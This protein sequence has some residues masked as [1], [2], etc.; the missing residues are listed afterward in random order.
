MQLGQ[1]FAG[2]AQGAPAP[3]TEEN[4]TELGDKLATDF[5]MSVLG[6]VGKMDLIIRDD[7]HLWIELIYA[8]SKWD[9]RMK[10]S[11]RNTRKETGCGADCTGQAYMV[12]CKVLRS[13]K[14]PDGWVA[15]AECGEYY[16]V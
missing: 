9:L 10:T 2:L 12:S 15:V 11:K 3:V 16:D 8:K 1:P 6:E 14:T 7:A 4:M 5:A 13:Y